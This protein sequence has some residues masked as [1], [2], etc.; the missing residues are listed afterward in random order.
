MAL[1]RFRPKTR[2]RGDFWFLF[3]ALL[4]ALIGLIMISSASVVNSFDR[5][6]YNTYFLTKQ[7]ISL[8]IGIVAMIIFAVVDYRFW[9]RYAT[10]FL[11]GGLVLLILTHFWGQTIGGARRWLQV[12]SLTVQ[13]SE[14]IK[15]AYIIYA[16]AW[17]AS[18]KEQIKQL[19]VGVIPFV[20]I[21]TLL[22]L[23]II[24]QPDLS[25]VLVITSTAMMMFFVAGAS[26]L[27]MVF[28]V[29]LGA[30]FFI[31][32]IKSASYRWQ[33]ILTFFN[34]ASDPLGA[35]YQIT[36]SLLAIGSGGIWGLGFGQS[37]QKYL[38]LPQ[39][40]TDSIFAVIM[41]ELGYIRGLLIILLLF[42][43]IY[44]G[45]SLAINLRDPFARLV[46][47]GISFWIAFQTLVNIG[48]TIGL[49]PL[50]GIPLPFISYGGS[51]LI[52]LMA[53]VGLLYNI[54]KQAEGSY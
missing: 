31:S 6:G 51:S 38:Y 42:I 2:R 13:S 22:I 44:K 28:S 50:T 29:G 45:I 19:L 34:P 48:A 54:S 16:A 11:I 14:V 21:L 8:G 36:Q 1:E 33:R 9:E 53:A 17:L 18:K 49:L 35:G 25:T 43:L 24:S 26:R 39:P 12:G 52:V 4:L 27:H 23:L 40:Y 5:Y 7:A 10:Y 47:A 15:L 32:L 3:L 20:A 37:R 30:I 46:A 41:E